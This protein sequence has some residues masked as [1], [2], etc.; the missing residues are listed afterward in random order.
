ML[1]CTKCH[2]AQA[3]LT[4]W[5]NRILTRAGKSIAYMRVFTGQLAPDYLLFAKT[6]LDGL[7][8]YQAYLC[9]GR[10]RVNQNLLAS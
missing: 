5:Q 2:K 9:T 8:P 1:Q 4:N 10:M 7:L 6:D 3:L